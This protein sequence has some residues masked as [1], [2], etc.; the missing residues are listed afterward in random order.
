MVTNE[1][2]GHGGI[3]T[4]V[5]VSK[6][7]ALIDVLN[8]AIFL[9]EPSP[10]LLDHLA[11]LR[12]W[13]AADQTARRSVHILEILLIQPGDDLLAAVNPLVPVTPD[14]RPAFTFGPQQL[15]TLMELPHA[16]RDLFRSL[17]HAYVVEG[18]GLR[19]KVLFEAAIDEG[20][21]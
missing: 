12:P 3:D 21:Q 1:S 7:Q 17:R 9:L 13:H 19:M 15:N 2:N 11:E 14:E 16:F 8:P 10:V 20:T 4:Y 5:V 18:E 6:Y